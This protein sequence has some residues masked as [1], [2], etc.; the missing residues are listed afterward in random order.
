MPNGKAFF[1]NCFASLRPG[2]SLWI[3]DLIEHTTPTIQAMM[4]QRYGEY[5]AA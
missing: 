5:L 1:G 2:G 3:S 4:W